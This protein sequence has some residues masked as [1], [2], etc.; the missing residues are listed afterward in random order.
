MDWSVSGAFLA[1]MNAKNRGDMKTAADLL[2]LALTASPG[3]PGL[4]QATLYAEI[5]DGRIGEGIKLAKQAREKQPAAAALAPLV[6]VLL[7]QD[8]IKHGQYDQALDAARKLPDQQIGKYAGPMMRA[9]LIAGSQKQVAAALK[10][11]KPLESEPGFAPFA[12]IQRAAIEDFLGHPDDA[13]KSY[14]QATDASSAIPTLL[15]QMYGNLLVRRGDKAGLEKL[16]DRFE[17]SNAGNSDVIAGPLEKSLRS[18]EKQKPSVASVADGVAGVMSGMSV[19]LL[20]ENLYNEALLFARLGL[21]LKPDL[22]IAKVLAG[23]IYRRTNRYDDAIAMYRSID[24]AS[25]YSWSAKLSVADCLRR[26]DKNDEAE[27]LL[28]DMT[29]SDRNNVE[30]PELLGDLLRGTNKFDAAADAYTTAI[31]RIANPLPNDWSLFYF[32]GTA[33]ER[34][35]QWPKA[36]AD[37]KKA[38]ELSPDQPYVLNYLAYTWV[39]RRE[40]LDEALKMLQTAVDARPEEGFIVDSLGWAHYQLGHYQDAVKYLERAVALSPQ[41]ATLNDHLGDA[42]WRAGRHIEARF[43]WSRALSFRPED[44]QVKIIEGK[45]RDGLAPVPAGT[46]PAPGDNKGTGGQSGTD[47]GQ[48]GSSGGTIKQNAG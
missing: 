24:A 48:N 11:L 44:D 28:R 9:W 3:D 2:P 7:A 46:A 22:D 31:G 47:G 8:A 13:L 16:L 20:Q 19:L 42:Y 27:K 45:V 5:S 26:E 39:E 36:E 4:I 40:H 12:M 43:Q 35:N 10:E 21:D 34:S 6:T 1:G 15:L 18:G 37:F 38:L 25:I 30:A 41:D 14:Q 17:S 33:Y 29:A 23:D 32:R